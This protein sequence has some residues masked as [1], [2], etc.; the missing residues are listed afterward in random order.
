MLRLMVAI[1]WY[2]YPSTGLNAPVSAEPALVRFGKVGNCVPGGSAPRNAAKLK[3]ARTSRLACHGCT[4]FNCSGKRAGSAAAS[5]ASL[6]R[7]AET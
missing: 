4:H 5:N 6:P 3:L 2:E 1:S 7:M